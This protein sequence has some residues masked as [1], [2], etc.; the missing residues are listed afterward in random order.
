MNRAEWMGALAPLIR[1][2]SPLA[3]ATQLGKML[4]FLA[5]IPDAAFTEA[6]ISTIAPTLKRSPSFAELRAA[7]QAY[8]RS[9]D[10]PTDQD[11]LQDTATMRERARWA[12]RQDELRAEWND[13]DGIRARIRTCDGELR[14]LRLLAGLVLQWAP[15]HLCLL[16]PI[17][18]VSLDDVGEVLMPSDDHRAT[19]RYLTPVQLD[20]INPL[21]GRPRDATI[22]A[23]PAAELRAA[24]VGPDAPDWDADADAIP[25]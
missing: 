12:A 14:F 6:S 23:A 18:L 5:D 25:F 10:A 8:V 15:Q 9:L 22:A 19:P 4:E 1:P 17:A 20:Q 24:P 21:P 7:L 2:R 3:A 16:P 13:P 11:P